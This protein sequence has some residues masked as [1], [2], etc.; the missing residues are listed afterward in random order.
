MY[1][2]YKHRCLRQAQTKHCKFRPWLFGIAVMA[3]LSLLSV[4]STRGAERI[5]FPDQAFALD[6]KAD[7]CQ[8]E[9]LGSLNDAPIK[10]ITNA[11]KQ[12]W[13]TV[14]FVFPSNVDLSPYSAVLIEIETEFSSESARVYI[15]TENDGQWQAFPSAVSSSL[16]PPKGKPTVVAFPLGGVRRDYTKAIRMTW[17]SKEWEETNPDIEGQEKILLIHGISVTSEPQTTNLDQ[18]NQPPASDLITT[19]NLPARNTPFKVAVYMNA[20]SH[21]PNLHLGRMMAQLADSGVDTISMIVYQFQ[22]LAPQG[23]VSLAK[24]WGITLNVGVSWPPNIDLAEDSVKT[25]YQHLID[26][27]E[28]YDT[29]GVVS[30]WY[31][32]DE[33]ETNYGPDKQPERYLSRF[34]QIMKALD[35]KRGTI[36]NHTDHA[37]KW[38]GK[39]LN[40]GEDETWCSVFWANSGAEKRLDKLL[41]KYRQSFPQGRGV[42]AVFGAQ[43]TSKAITTEENRLFQGIDGMTL[44]QLKG[45]STSRDIQDYVETAFRLGFI[46]AALFAYDAYYDYTW[47]SLVDERGRSREGRLEGLR[48]GVVAI[49][50][51]QGH[52]TVSLTVET[53][54]PNNVV[55]SVNAVQGKRTIE[56][57]NV[58]VSDDGGYTW[59]SI[60]GFE[61]TGGVVDYSP[62]VGWQR[63]GWLIIRARAF[64]GEMHSLWS[65]WN[66]FPARPPNVS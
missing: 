4:T 56:S 15:D 10:V 60:D 13:S 53:K 12:E 45:R 48:A 2:T 54:E 9:E 6:I 25:A 55:V 66:V 22:Q 51:A 43:G 65:V 27:I 64:D 63:V 35:P 39:M 58:E 31:I 38:D 33:V 30:D 1:T 14:T 46:G 32:A 36:I 5:I 19:Q 3:A 49:R 28:K 20:N 23:L 24:D 29:T 26:T 8:I 37:L 17:N 40:L 41:A 61:K 7:N 16:L 18:E 11:G 44:A 52:P 34:V 59:A 47:Y 50:K 62:K 57:L 21:P 42:V